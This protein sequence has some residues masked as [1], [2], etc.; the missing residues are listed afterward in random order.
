MTPATFSSMLRMD[1]SIEGVSQHEMALRDI[2]LD[3]GFDSPGNFTRFFV[4]QQ[5]VTPS[6]YR[7][8]VQ[9]VSG[10]GR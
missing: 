1:L 2:A 10:Q 8:N 9:F 6:Q 4:R 3:L 7:Q 5:G